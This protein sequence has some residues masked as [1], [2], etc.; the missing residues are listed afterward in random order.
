MKRMVCWIIPALFLLA[1]CDTDRKLL[2]PGRMDDDYSAGPKSNLLDRRLAP[3]NILLYAGDLPKP[4][5][6]LNDLFTDNAKLTMADATFAGAWKQ[7]AYASMKKESYGKATEAAKVMLARGIVVS[8]R[9]CANWFRKLSESQAVMQMNADLVGNTGALAGAIMGL[10]NTAGPVIGGTAAATGFLQNEAAS[11]QANLIVA[12]DVG[13][14]Q[15][16]I[17]LNRKA[18]ATTLLAPAQITYE[19]ALSGLISY[20]NDCTHAAVKRLVNQSIS[21]NAD[22][23]AALSNPV[24]SLLV[25]TL[26]SD[27]LFGPQF[28]LQP[29]DVINLYGYLVMDSAAASSKFAA[30]LTSRKLLV[31]GAIQDSHGAMKAATLAAVKAI[32]SA[33]STAAVLN[34]AAANGPVT[35]AAG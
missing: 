3:E 22:S 15:E 17:N 5:D 6:P 12:P 24:L 31:N 19:D 30:A 27:T 7:A 28:N 8:D 35:T 26:Q 29:A 4:G 20:D 34:A 33:S 2:N 21:K 11:I 23:T 32:L 13:L 18:K 9:L 10:T 16:L 25:S 14:V 1:G